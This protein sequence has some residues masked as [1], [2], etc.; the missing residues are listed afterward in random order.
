MNKEYIKKE[1]EA[2]K[3]L[4][5]NGFRSAGYDFV[6]GVVTVVHDKKSVNEFNTYY[7]FKSFQEAADK[8]L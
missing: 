6:H 2:V 7:Y 5:R 4:E 8:L 1:N 3:E